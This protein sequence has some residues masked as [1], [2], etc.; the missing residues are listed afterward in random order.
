[1]LH[2]CL[3]VSTVVEVEMLS[4]PVKGEE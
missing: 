2:L 3:Y 4:A 1:M